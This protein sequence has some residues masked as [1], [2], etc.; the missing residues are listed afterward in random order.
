MP[1][2]KSDFLPDRNYLAQIRRPTRS[3]LQK[4]LSFL[5]VQEQ[6][7][8]TSASGQAPPLLEGYSLTGSFFEAIH[9]SHA[10][11]EGTRQNQRET[12]YA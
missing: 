7:V 4:N 9:I 5:S 2:L 12:V 8:S 6:K 3:I 11:V 1:A 10:R